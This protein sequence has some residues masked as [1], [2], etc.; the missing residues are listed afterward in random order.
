MTT[1]KKSYKE[2]PAGGIT[3]ETSLDYET[4]AWRSKKPVVNDE[5][6]TRCLECYIYCP[7]SSIKYEDDRIII[8]YS[9]CK[10]C[11]IC[12]KECPQ[13]AIDMVEEEK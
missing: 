3:C 8:D 13:D 11:G 9:H 7:D 1:K 2:M 4:G 5:K 6:C 10:G 12:A